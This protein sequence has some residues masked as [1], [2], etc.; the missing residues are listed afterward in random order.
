MTGHHGKHTHHGYA[1]S[2]WRKKVVLKFDGRCAICG[3]KTELEAHHVRG[4]TEFPDEQ[5]VVDNGVVLC[6]N[7]HLGV[8]RSAGATIIE[9]EKELERVN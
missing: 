6:H 7:C 4:Y 1:Y 9:D 3:A 5:Y 8:H 2:T